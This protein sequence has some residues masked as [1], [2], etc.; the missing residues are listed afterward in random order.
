MSS[1]T[2]AIRKRNG[3]D[4]ALAPV[5]AVGAF[6]ARAVIPFPVGN[7]SIT[8]SAL[9]PEPRPPE[10]QRRPRGRRQ[11]EALRQWAQPEELP[12]PE[13]RQPELR[14]EQP[15]PASRR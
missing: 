3:P 6:Q 11:P 4:R 14:Q 12:R 5:R 15:L 7:G 2:K 13:L 1:R 9:R 10:Q 8:A